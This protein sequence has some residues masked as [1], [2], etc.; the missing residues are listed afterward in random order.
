M[1]SLFLTTL[2]FLGGAVQAVTLYPLQYQVIEEFAA[3]ATQTYSG[4]LYTLS[5]NGSNHNDRRPGDYPANFFTYLD[6]VMFGCDNRISTQEAVFDLTLATGDSDRRG[7]LAFAYRFRAVGAGLLTA[8]FVMLSIDP[9]PAHLQYRL[10]NLSTSTVLSEQESSSIINNFPGNQY[11]V[12]DGEELEIMGRLDVDTTG[13]TGFQYST[14]VGY[15]RIGSEP[16]PEPS[17]AI[18]LGAGAALVERRRRKR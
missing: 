12:N 14:G 8:N 5:L 17:S 10:T 2:V 13:L 7:S 11:A 4:S 16:V 15:I 18:A 9:V 6:S 3:N 1:K